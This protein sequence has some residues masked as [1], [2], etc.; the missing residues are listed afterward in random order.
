ME[1]FDQYYET[2][3]V[4]VLTAVQVTTQPAF[5]LQETDYDAGDV[6]VVTNVQSVAISS[7]DDDIV[8]AI[9]SVDAPA[10]TLNAGNSTNGFLAGYSITLGTTTADLQN[11]SAAAQVWTQKSGF[12]GEPSNPVG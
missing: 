9:T 1:N 6:N 4:N 8:E 7:N 5:S 10:I 12:T 3:S 11:G 2:E